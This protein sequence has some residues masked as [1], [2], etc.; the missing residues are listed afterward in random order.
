[1]LEEII[2]LPI[3]S[4]NIDWGKIDKNSYLCK[5]DAIKSINNLEFKK[6]ITIFAGENGSGKCRS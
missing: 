3:R 6:N 4:V 2:N 5:I 1:M